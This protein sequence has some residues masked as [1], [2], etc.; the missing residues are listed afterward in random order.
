MKMNPEL[1]RHNN[2]LL[3]ALRLLGPDEADAIIGESTPELKVLHRAA[4]SLAMLNWWKATVGGMKKTDNTMKMQAQSQ[5]VLLQLVHNAYALGMRAG[6]ALFSSSTS[7]SYPTTS[8]PWATSTPS[9]DN[10]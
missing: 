1:K 7:A 6:K 10:D 8:G 5:V 9:K 4:E 3:E 2:R